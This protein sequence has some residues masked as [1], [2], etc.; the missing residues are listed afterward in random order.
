MGG[1][2]GGGGGGVGGLEGRGRGGTQFRI[3]SLR[4]IRKSI[5]DENKN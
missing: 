1:G 2:G 5:P 4:V 3:L